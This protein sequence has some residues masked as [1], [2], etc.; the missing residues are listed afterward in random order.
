MFRK[1][2]QL[3]IGAVCCAALGSGVALSD[4]KKAMTPEEQAKMMEQCM[5]M[6]QP[7]E[8]HQML[9]KYMAGKW[10]YVTKYW[11][12]PSA[13]PNEAKGEANTVS[14]YGDR[15]FHS[16]H[17]GKMMMPGADGQMQEMDFKGTSVTAYDNAKGKFVSVWMDNMS[18]GM[19]IAEGAYD[20]AT[21]TFNYTGEMADMMNPSGPKVKFREVIKVIDENK[22]IFEWYETRDGHEMKMMEITYTRK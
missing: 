16:E 12:D 9:K 20:P 6:G 5:L 4:D 3:S 7:G 15:Y 18:T 17:E 11:M 19:F 14:V 1:W 13:P 21:K 22:H 2:L 10:D 8:Q